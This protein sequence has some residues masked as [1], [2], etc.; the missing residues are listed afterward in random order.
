MLPLLSLIIHFSGAY[1][2]CNTVLWTA[3]LFGVLL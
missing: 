2:F 1:N 3:T